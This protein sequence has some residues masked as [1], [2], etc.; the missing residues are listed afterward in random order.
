MPKKTQKI[1]LSEHTLDI[2]TNSADI[3]LF[4]FREVEEYVRTLTGSREYQFQA[5]K[6]LLTY[7]WG[8]RYDTVLDLAKENWKKKEALQQRFQ[9]EDHFLG[10]LPLPDRLSGVCHMATGTGK[11]YVM[12]AVSYLSLLMDKV[13]RVLI[14]GPSSTVIEQ[15][16]TDKFKE[17]LFGEKAHELRD[18]LPEKYRHKVIKL[19]NAND[20]IEDN[21]IVIENVNAVW[22][23][24]SNAIGDTLFARGSRVL[25]LS[26]EVHH[27][28]S[29]LTFDGTRLNYD[30]KEKDLD[31]LSR[32]SEEAGE[33]L[34]MKF[35]REKPIKWHLGF[36]GTPYNQD[37]YFVDVVFNYSIRDAAEDKFIK[38]IDAVLTVDGDEELTKE[39]RFIQIIETHQKNKTLYSYADNDGNARIKPISIFIHSTQSAAKKNAQ[40]FAQ[41]LAEYLKKNEEY[42]DWD[43]AK[44]EAL[45]HSKIIT[46][47]S[48]S[49][50]SE[51]QKQL[52]QI[53]ELDP[54]KIGGQVEFIFSVNKLSEGWDVDNVFQIIPSQERVFNSKLLISQV[55]GRGLRKPRKVPATLLDQRY[56]TVT[57]T[58]H[59]KFGQHVKE[60]YD[61]VTECELRFHSR[62]VDESIERGKHHFSLFNITHV[63]VQ[64][65]EEKQQ[66]SSTKRSLILDPQPDSLGVS[67]QYLKGVRKFEFEKEFFTVAQVVN[68][69][70]RKFKYVAFEKEQ[71]NIDDGTDTNLFPDRRNIESVIRDSMQ[72]AGI[73]TEKI[74]LENKKKIELYFNQ[75]ISKGTKKVVR[76]NVSGDIFGV[77]TIRLPSA[78]AN[79]GRLDNEVSV[80]ISEDYADELLGDDLFIISELEKQTKK[81]EKKTGKGQQGLFLDAVQVKSEF[82][83]QLLSTKNIYCVNP[84]VFKTPQSSVLVSHKPEREFVVQL[85]EHAKFFD[86]WIKSTDAGFYSLDYEYWKGGKD[87]VRR[88]FNPD[89]FMIADLTAYGLMMSNPNAKEIVRKLENSGI[90]KIIF[91]VEIKGQDD[92]Q[93]VTIAKENA[94]KDHFVEVNNKL[95]SINPTNIEEEFQNDY[96]QHYVFNLLR[97]EDVASWFKRLKDGS[98]ILDSYEE[99]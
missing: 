63:P 91:S 88:S 11:T 9:S 22:S 64:R 48:D 85:I 23:A 94:G 66:Q 37:E 4:D 50:V 92:Y 74:S 80:F 30:F 55:L 87:R 19:L 5:I 65:T 93:D 2:K 34:W 47:T 61:Q 13:D 89:F 15:G 97:E 46:V 18:L 53:E 41:V 14:I 21:S 42:K 96:R 56:P 77:S 82:I 81:Q 1:S 3:S 52:E 98:L 99:N 49:N 25:V 79:I 8:G 10:S 33:R 43:R 62:V 72:S 35:L 45:A 51:Y 16:I 90:E 84:S 67:I 70:A 24:D 40:E 83:R 57:V 78:T 31:N 59:E 60:L 6:T 86:S 69:I 54:N 28:Y 17:Y 71:F 29:H 68:D 76:E 7:L 20:P 58:N 26:D 75:F 44:L 38:D 32:I 36:T 27:A 73:T 95:R 12:F 39:Q